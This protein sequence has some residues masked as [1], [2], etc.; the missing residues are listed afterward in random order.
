VDDAV[1]ELQQALELSYRYLNSRDRTEAEI[2]GQL[3]R[4]GVAAA[5]VDRAL[6]TLTDDGF[7]N[8]SR[9]ARYFTHD[10]RELEGWG[11]ERIRRGLRARGIDPDLVQSALEEEVPTPENGELARALEVLRRRFPLPPSDRHERDR[12]LGVLLRKGYDSDLALE[13]LSAYA[14]DF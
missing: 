2:R 5:V 11:A 6:A 14:R 10:K 1:D 3:E 9:F 12:A 13:A 8:D 4:Q 7:V